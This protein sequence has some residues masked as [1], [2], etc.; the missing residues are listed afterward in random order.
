MKNITYKFNFLNFFCRFILPLIIIEFI[1]LVIIKFSTANITLITLIILMITLLLLEK[2][3]KSTFNLDPLSYEEGSLIGKMTG[4]EPSNRI[5]TKNHKIYSVKVLKDINFGFLFI[6]ITGEINCF[7]DKN[8]YVNE[9]IVKS[10]KIPRVFKITKNEFN[11][12]I[13]SFSMNG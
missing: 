8:G 4:S 11:K 13:N 7:I 10:I 12:T 2:Y 9:K 1:L 6:T 5:Y 3:N